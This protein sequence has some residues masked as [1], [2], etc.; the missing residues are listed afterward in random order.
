MLAIEMTL[1]K[2]Y[3]RRLCFMDVGLVSDSE[4]K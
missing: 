4:Q 3:N 1:A 2:W